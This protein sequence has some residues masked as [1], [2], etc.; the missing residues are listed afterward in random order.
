MV[1]ITSALEVDLTGQV[2]ADSIGDRFY[3]GF[4]GQVDFIRGAARSEQGKPI[5][6]LLST[7]KNG[8]LG[9]IVARLQPG[10]GVVTTRADVHYVVTEYG[11]AQLHG[12]SVR[13]RTSALIHIAHPKF[14]DGLLR[15]AR[16]RHLVHPNQIAFPAS[17]QPYPKKYEITAAFKRGL[18]IFFR[19]IQ[20]TDEGF[21]KELFYSHSQQTIIQ[22]Y[23]TP[24]RR[25]PHE[26][27]QKFVTLDY[28]DQMA[29][30]GLVPF[31][32]RERMICV[33]RY[34]RDAATNEAEVAVTI[35]D[36]YQHRG[37]GTF[38]LKYVMR[39]AFENGVR[40]FT[41]DVLAENHAM[42]AL[43]HKV[44]E[45]VEASVESGVYHVRFALDCPKPNTG[46]PAPP[47]ALAGRAN[48][49]PRDPLPWPARI[50]RPMAPTRPENRPNRCL[51]RGWRASGPA[52]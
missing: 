23:F 17:L 44:A 42:M 35:H 32:G 49:L 29:I 4:G 47:C 48:P 52:G 46:S 14:R 21:L 40:A 28:H 9:R 33:G 1:A 24:L 37:V 13:E 15:E 45:K 16:E 18:K 19:P 20:P 38:L 36:D 8:E 22:R 41:A 26:Q 30:V 3:S 6:A 25:L 12:K 5:I 11:I 27:V 39:V 7:A 10:A 34:F 50:R 2:C 51:A 31:E 43:F